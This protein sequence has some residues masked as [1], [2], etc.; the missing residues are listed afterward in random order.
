[1][2]LFL[3]QIDW[4]KWSPEAIF[5]GQVLERTPAGLSIIYIIGV[6]V[7]LGFLVLT[8][9]DN[10]NRPKFLFE[11]DL[12]KE[13]K[14]KLTQTIANRSIRAWQVVFILLAFGVFGFQ[15]YWTYFAD[16]SNEKFQELAYKD[17]RNRRTTAANL[18][19]WML[20]RNGKLI[21]ALAYYKKNQDG[22]IVRA[23]SL[24]REMA[25]LLGTERGTPGL[26]RT[27]YRRKADPAP[28]AWEVLTTIKRKEDED[29]D[30]KV[31]IDKELQSYIA[32]QLEGKRGAIVI[33]NPQNGDILAMYSNPSFSL[34]E[35][36]SLD[37]YLKLEGNK[38]D[39]PL[40]NRTNR[41]FYVPGSTFKLF[42]MISA[43]RAGKQ[44]A[45][46]ASFADGFRPTRGSLPIVDST[47][48]REGMNVSGACSGGCEEKDIRTAFKV[49]SNQY[50]AQ[51]AIELGRERLRETA[52]QL[53]ISPVDTPEEAVMSKFFPL[54]MNASNQQIANS[55]APQ[56]STLVVGKDI[57]LFDIGLEGMGQGY[58]GQ[59]TPFQ[60]ALITAAAGNLEG[61]LMKPRIEMDQAPQA[62][63]QPLTPQ[64]AAVIREIMSTV[65]EEPGG[66][67]VV[68][69]GK[70]AGTGIRAGGKTGTAEKQVPLYDEK[71]GQLKTT[72]KRRRNAAGEME[73]YKVP[74]MVERSDSWFISLA[75]IEKPTF[76]IAVVV[77]GGGYGSKTAAPMAANVIL[78]ARELG[79]LGDQYRPKAAPHQAPARRPAA[80]RPQ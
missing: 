75:P 48:H 2:L 13:V 52:M 29:K 19:G 64:Q 51:L 56:Q 4:S 9:F 41:E 24:E 47:Q 61:K 32:K 12:P 46:F 14:K 6:G 65:T 54:I 42:T 23:F 79:L 67:G 49:S 3:L 8:F 17:L 55:L 15:V 18:R 68:I 39:K 38:R 28:E 78:K 11:F 30:V 43:F 20:D 35:A 34:D 33:L 53:G 45:R 40:L 80:R 50:F 37:N 66:T 31:T 16:E 74:V 7:L 21:D 69:A 60:M 44:N 1:M 58:A 25:H 36:Q 27:L 73:E 72:T 22:D 63:S 26:E 57:S 71:T 62:F 77:E 59:M 70:L 5:G 10:F 76:A